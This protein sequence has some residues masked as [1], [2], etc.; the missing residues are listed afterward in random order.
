MHLLTWQDCQKQTNHA[1]GGMAYREVQGLCAEALV[2]ILSPVNKLSIAYSPEETIKKVH[3][4][5]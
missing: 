2:L 1:A 3:N 5:T 4:L